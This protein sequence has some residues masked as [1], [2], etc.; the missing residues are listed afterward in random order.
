MALGHLQTTS[1]AFRCPSI[2]PVLLQEPTFCTLGSS[3]KTRSVARVFSTSP[4]AARR[5]PIPTV[6]LGK[7]LRILRPGKAE[8]GENRC[9]SAVVNT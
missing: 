2:R 1:D 3:S 5:Q 9:Q 8:D 4:L 6:P 7:S